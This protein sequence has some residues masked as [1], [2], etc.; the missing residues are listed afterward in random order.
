MFLH[1]SIGEQACDHITHI[2]N[3]CINFIPFPLKQLPFQAEQA[4][5]SIYLREQHPNPPNM[6][7]TVSSIACVFSVFIVNIFDM[8]RP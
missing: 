7:V 1:H 4:S 3:N 6:L 5:V 8:W 2:I